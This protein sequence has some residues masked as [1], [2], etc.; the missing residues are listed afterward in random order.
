M[1]H[2]VAFREEG[3]RGKGPRP[4]NVNIFE[5]LM[6]L[7]ADCHHLID[8]QPA[9]YPVRALRDHK[10]EH[11]DR[12]SAVTALGPE[13]RTTVIQ[14]RG[15]IGGQPVDIPAADIREALHPRYPAR[16][17]GALIDLTSFQRESESFFQLAQEQIRRELQPAL[18][19]ELERK[20]VQ[21]YS[22]FALAPIP[23]LACFGREIGNKVTVDIFPR[24]KDRAPDRPAWGWLSTGTIAGYELRKL[25]DGTEPMSVALL[26]SL[27]GRID[28]SSLPSDMDIRFTL[29][30]ISLVGQEP[31]VDFLRRREDLFEFRN[32]YRDALRHIVTAHP[33]LPQLHLLPAVPAPIAIA[34]GQELMPKA[35][36]ELVVYDRVKETFVHAITI[37]TNKDL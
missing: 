17:P 13:Y 29:Y 37:N 12:I 30:E 22:V 19:A 33:G 16:L 35:H 32:S 24:H 2:I 25:R 20:R 10:R 8:T 11:E 18:R 23:V 14:V 1:A 31:N 34:C 28:L 21:H 6:L 15:T 4:R 36:P 3:P 26:L 9:A 5:N 27:S 7:C